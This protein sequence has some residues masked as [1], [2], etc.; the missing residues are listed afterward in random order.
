MTDWAQEK[1][2]T[3]MQRIRKFEAL[4]QRTGMAENLSYTIDSISDGAVVYRYTP[5]D[6]H[7]NLIGSLHGG[8]LASLIDTAMGAAVMT[9][10]GAGELHTMTDL[11]IKFI[12]AVREADEELIIEAQ[13]DHAGKRMFATQGT[14]K[15]TSGRL[16]ARAVASAIRL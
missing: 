8:I 15:S 6:R 3:G 9:K 5:K 7:Q 4:E 11:T 2:L 13:V 12:G 1:H 16:I 10:L 14:I